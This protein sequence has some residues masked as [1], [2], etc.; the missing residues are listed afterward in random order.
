MRFVK[1]VILS[2]G[3]V[4]GRLR[5]K[6]GTQ[7]KS[8]IPFGGKNLLL[9]AIEAVLGV[10]QVEKPIAVVGPSEIRIEVEKFG[11]DVVWLMEGAG[12]MDN[13]QS[14]VSFF[15]WNNDFLL[16]SPDLPLVTSEDFSSFLSSIPE[17]AELAVPIIR[18]ED[19]LNAFP[20]SPN[21]FV[22]LLEGQVTMGSTFFAKGSALRKNIGLGRDAYKARKN[23]LKLAFMLGLPIVIGNI[24]GRCSLPVI[25]KR[26]SFLV[27]AKAKGVIVNLPRLAYDVDNEMN[28]RYLDELDIR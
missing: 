28:L 8:L 11:K 18:K 7:V 27:D 10:P 25:E 26:V 13:V 21:K 19:F 15:G 16:V 14:G 23:I 17:E 2:G 4:G 20:G 3:R 22:R 6:Y 24:F 5:K 1:A 9:I 12:I